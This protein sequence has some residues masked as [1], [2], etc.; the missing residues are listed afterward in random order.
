[1]TNG[2]D[3]SIRSPAETYNHVSV[4]DLPEKHFKN[5]PLVVK[6]L[7]FRVHS[8]HFSPHTDISE[9]CNLWHDAQETKAGRFFYLIVLANK[10]KDLRL[11]VSLHFDA[12]V[13]KCVCVCGCVCVS[14]GVSVGVCVCTVDR[15]N[16]WV[17]SV[18]SEVPPWPSRGLEG[19][20]ANSLAKQSLRCTQ[21]TASAVLVGCL[22]SGPQVDRD[23]AWGKLNNLDCLN[24]SEVNIGFDSSTERLAVDVN[25]IST[26]TIGWLISSSS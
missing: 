9:E 23:K 21:I 20:C 13:F 3:L 10:H 6:K 16:N 1:M 18:C 14:L 5:P 4:A 12:R 26:V 19:N 15:L 2:S 7:Y 8:S 22:S 11:S 24:M 17:F 25:A